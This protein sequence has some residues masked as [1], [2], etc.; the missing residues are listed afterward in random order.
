VR[1]ADERELRLLEALAT[2]PSPAAAPAA[3]ALPHLPH[4]IHH[5]EAV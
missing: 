4:P 5:K 1:L 3:D 2:S